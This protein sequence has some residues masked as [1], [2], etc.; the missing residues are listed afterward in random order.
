MGCASQTWVPGLSAATRRP[1]P[2]HA[3]VADCFSSDCVLSLER[4]EILQMH[5]SR[6]CK[7]VYT[8]YVPSVPRR[9]VC[10]CVRRVVCESSLGLIAG[11]IREQ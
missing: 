6:S 5:T 9:A 11:V 10:A 8:V 1:L 2:V 4:S 3:D 7:D